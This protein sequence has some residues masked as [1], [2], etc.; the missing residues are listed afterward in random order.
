[1]FGRKPRATRRLTSS[2]AAP[3][4]SA[5][6]PSVRLSPRERS[7]ARRQLLQESFFRRDIPCHEFPARAPLPSPR[8]RQRPGP[9]TCPGS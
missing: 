4:A 7:L 8:C 9:R 2:S 1:M 5:F 6:R 3:W